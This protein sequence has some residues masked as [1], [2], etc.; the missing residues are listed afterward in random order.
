MK[1]K[2]NYFSILEIFKN[3]NH[4][5]AT[6]NQ[7]QNPVRNV[8]DYAERHAE[9]HA[10]DGWI[11]L[12]VLNKIIC[13]ECRATLSAAW[14]AACLQRAMRS[15]LVSKFHPETLIIVLFLIRNLIFQESVSTTQQRNRLAVQHAADNAADTT[16]RHP[17]LV[18]LSN[19]FK[20]KAPLRRVVRRVVRRGWRRAVGCALIWS[21][22]ICS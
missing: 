13:F 1:F 16:E 15:S 18:I 17:K 12:N 19:T 2:D 22:R 21:N 7:L 14:S 10:A 8:A 6:E 5:Y 11:L 9:R 20:K 4:A 3:P